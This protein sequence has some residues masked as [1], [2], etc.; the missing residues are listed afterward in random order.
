MACGGCFAGISKGASIPKR[1]NPGNKAVICVAGLASSALERKTKSTFGTDLWNV[2]YCSIGALVSEPRTTLES[3]KLKLVDGKLQDGTPCKTTA[4][5][6]GEEV[7][8]YDGME[9]I[10]VLNPGEP[11]PVA[12]WKGLI[13]EHEDD[14]NFDILPYDWRRFGDLAY[15]ETLPEIFKQ[16][17]ERSLATTTHPSGK[18]SVIAHSMGA[19]VVLYCL[20]KLGDDWVK[21]NVGDCVLVAPAHAGSPV[22][23]PS[24]GHAPFVATLKLPDAMSK[25]TTETLGS[26]CASWPCMLGEMPTNVGGDEAWESDQVF[27]T[28]PGR[29]YKLD[30]LGQ[31]LKDLSQ[32]CENREM[33]PALWPGLQKIAEDMKCPPVQT[34]LVV[35]SGTDTPIQFAYDSSDLSGV[36][37][38]TQ[39]SPGDGTVVTSSV[40]K[41]AETW[42]EQGHNVRVFEC[43]GDV[44]H[45]S[46]IV[47]DFVVGLFPKFIKNTTLNVL[48]VTIESAKDLMNKDMFSLSDPFVEVKIKHKKHSMRISKVIDNNLNPSWNHAATIYAWDD[49]ESLSCHVYDDDPM[50]RQSLG[51]VDITSDQIK[52]GFDGELQLIDGTGSIKVKVSLSE[53]GELLPI[54]MARRF[55][56]ALVVGV[57]NIGMQLF[58]TTPSNSPRKGSPTNPN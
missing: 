58:G 34:R 29:E 38:I 14:Y 9:G 23:A 39:T 50:G 7:R 12:V 49:G 41:L 48:E 16:R 51:H 21:K 4:D 27:V 19:P 17:V 54:G 15:T 8:P 45:K 28:T 46:L 47:S 56:E 31:F 52:A 10:K 57:E 20:S 26:L 6:D 53:H 44:S 11:I 35:C 25:M 55:T 37:T 24:L 33:G 1:C 30:E 13:D 22:M 18:A 2:S 32:C 36:P 5:N 43:P 42:K 40:V 3:L